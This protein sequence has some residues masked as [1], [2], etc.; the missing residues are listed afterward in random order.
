[1]VD[2]VTGQGQEV[3]EMDGRRLVSIAALVLAGLFLSACTIGVDRNPDGSLRVDVNLPEAT[4]Q[5]EIDQGLND[6]LIKDLNADLRE[7]YIFVTADRKRVESDVVDQLTFRLDLGVKDGN[8]TAAISE[9]QIN[10]KAADPAYVDVWNQRLA[11]RLEKAGRRNPD[12]TLQ[13]VTISGDAVK[14][15]WRIETARSRGEQ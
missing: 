7:G 11:N 4:I 10:G 8:L 2:T 13:S 15:V 14:F 9:V 3:R 1:M 12:A 5:D 6:P